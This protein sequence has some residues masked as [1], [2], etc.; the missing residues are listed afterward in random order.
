[1]K[2]HIKE[3]YFCLAFIILALLFTSNIAFA[4]DVEEWLKQG[5]VL[6]ETEYHEENDTGRH[7]YYG[8]SLLLPSLSNGLVFDPAIGLQKRE[9]DGSNNYVGNTTINKLTIVIKLK[10]NSTE[11][12]IIN[13]VQEFVET[14]EGYHIILKEQVDKSGATRDNWAGASVVSISY[15]AADG[16]S[17]KVTS[18]STSSKSKGLSIWSRIGTWFSEVWEDI[19]KWAVDKI[20]DIFNELFV[21]LGDGIHKLI[22]DVYGTEITLEGIVYN[23]DPKLSINFW[24]DAKLSRAGPNG[25]GATMKIIV[26][27]CYSKLSLIALTFMIMMFLYT[28]IRIILAS[29][30]KGLEEAKRRLSAW[31]MGVAILFFYPYVMKYIVVLNEAL[32]DLVASKGSGTFE[33]V[34]TMRQIR[35]MAG[36]GD[37]WD[38]FPVKDASGKNIE[39]LWSLPLTIAFIIMNGQLIVMLIAYYKR[40]FSLAFMISIFPVIATYSMWEKIQS[41]KRRYITTLDK[42]ICRNCIYSIDSCDCLYNFNKRCFGNFS[43]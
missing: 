6:Q 17:S 42:R 26:R 2:A 18:I 7:D 19:K 34:D 28:V 41:G 15:E 1:M 10:D 20:A 38:G 32:V 16:S 14:N 39:G 37:D 23:T 22:R 40:A 3:V 12:I 13:P 30:G 31:A 9:Y 25:I 29:T 33:D 4:D 27:F 24:D 11:E 43:A 21:P 35:A 5:V 36:H 8:Y